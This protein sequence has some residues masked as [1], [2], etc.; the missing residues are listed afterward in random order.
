MMDRMVRFKLTLAYLGA[1]FCGWQIQP[2]A[3]TVQ[4]CL[5]AVVSRM[6]ARPTR[7]HGA[8]RTDAGV[9]ALGQ[10]A[11]L[12]VPEDKAALPWQRALNAQVD[13]DMAILD[14]Q[15]VE[16]EFHARYSPSRKSYSYTIWTEER[17]ILPQRRDLVWPLRPLDLVAMREAAG[18]LIGEHDFAA[19]QNVGTMVHHT[20][21]TIYEIRFEQG[22]HPCETRI[23][24]TGNGFLKQM[25]R[26][27]VGTLV[28]VGK[29]RAAPV[30]VAELLE[31]RDRSR[32]P[33]TA[34]AKGLC[35]EWIDYG[36]GGTSCPGHSNSG[37]SPCPE[38]GAR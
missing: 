19:F 9:H 26:N 25:V 36:C 6:L 14:V 30:H 33:E 15:A 27:M 1:G 31:G 8:S 24:F 35:L 13:R 21:R 32:V 12:D 11:H 10:V 29:G 20:M 37:S 4:G 3:R 34:P 2:N 38:S 23:L 5:E 18:H 22:Q 28:S 17:Y 7:I 16:R